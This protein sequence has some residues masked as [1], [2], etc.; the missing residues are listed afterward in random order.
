MWL[1][2]LLDD[3]SGMGIALRHPADKALQL[4]DGSFL[5]TGGEALKSIPLQL[6]ACADSPFLE[7]LCPKVV[8]MGQAMGG[9]ELCDVP[10][11]EMVGPSQGER[12]KQIVGDGTI[13]QM[14]CTA[15]CA[16]F[17]QSHSSCPGNAKAEEDQ[18]SEGEQTK[19]E[20]EN[21]DA[22]SLNASQSIG[23]PVASVADGPRTRVTMSLLLAVTTLM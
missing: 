23:D 7:Q 1:G 17:C 3:E 15:A 4:F 22:K 8:G 13:M 10:V 18:K 2:E 9:A 11:S 5:N 6:A 16:D 20:K 14:C 12:L 21:D 19:T